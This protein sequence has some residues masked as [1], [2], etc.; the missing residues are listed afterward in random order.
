MEDG[1]IKAHKYFGYAD[2]PSGSLKT[3]LED[4]SKLLMAYTNGGLYNN[5]RIL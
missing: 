4:Y 1:N 3:T 5:V 2:Y